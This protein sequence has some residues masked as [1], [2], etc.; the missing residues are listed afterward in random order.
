MSPSVALRRHPDQ[1]G[2]CPA[3]VGCSQRSSSRVGQ[4]VL[5]SCSGRHIPNTPLV[6][7]PSMDAAA[8]TSTLTVILHLGRDVPSHHLLHLSVGRQLSRDPSVGNAAG[9]LA[10][11][12]D[13]LCTLPCP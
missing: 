13:T 12:V 1:T 5:D 9:E 8:T 2:R 4:S 11:H 3:N 6:V 7:L 10:V